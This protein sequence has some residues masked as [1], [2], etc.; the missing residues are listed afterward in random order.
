MPNTVITS[1]GTTTGLYDGQNITL[2]TEADVTIL[3]ADGL[4]LTMSV[5]RTVWVDDNPL[6]FTVTL[7]NTSELDFVQPLTFKTNAFD[8]SVVT[9]D[10]SSVVVSG[11]TAGEVSFTGGVLSVALTENL[12]ALSGSATITFQLKKVA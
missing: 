1:N 3:L 11:N 12:V 5:D 10:T 6:N 8:T 2:P 4:T 7:T 9:I